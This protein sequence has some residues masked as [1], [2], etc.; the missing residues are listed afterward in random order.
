MTDYEFN[1]RQLDFCI[2][3]LEP[4]FRAEFCK[5]IG[6]EV[7]KV[8]NRDQHPSAH[9][10]I[11]DS[12]GTKGARVTT[13]VSYENSDY[14]MINK[15]AVYD[16]FVKLNLTEDRYKILSSVDYL[17]TYYN[18]QTELD[19]NKTIVMMLDSQAI[20]RYLDKFSGGGNAALIKAG[21]P[22][23][24]GFVSLPLLLLQ[25]IH[26]ILEYYTID[27]ANYSY[28]NMHG[29]TKPLLST[30][31]KRSWNHYGLAMS[32]VKKSVVAI[33]M[34]TKEQLTFESVK[35]AA[36]KVLLDNYNETD[37]GKKQFASAISCISNC[38]NGKQKKVL[39]KNGYWYAFFDYQEAKAL[40]TSGKW[41]QAV[42][43]RFKKQTRKKRT[44]KSAN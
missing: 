31:I 23:I 42:E 22:V 19:A 40:T 26:A 15:K 7:K 25:D 16:Y 17:F 1:F 10:I 38:I 43:D 28:T 2:N 39:G 14:D 36:I 30:N 41:K 8:I 24:S 37:I 44:L 35:E 29:L 3:N 32:P 5:K 18:S 13:A 33:C 34:E 6:D 20:V 4:F 27:W 9:L 21:L 11:R 12:E